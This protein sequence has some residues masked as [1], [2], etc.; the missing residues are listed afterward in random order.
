MNRKPGPPAALTA[1]ELGLLARLEGRPVP[2]AQALAAALGVDASAAGRLI[3]RFRREGVL[4][5]AGVA[6]RPDGACECISYLV[7]DWTKADPE[8]LEARLRCDPAVLTADRILGPADYRLFSRHADFR[9]A[10]AWVRALE[11]EPG[12][13]RVTARFCASVCDRPYY[14]AARL[15][16]DAARRPD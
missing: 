13:S 2:R 16:A 1:R 14:A 7:V 15:A 12:L 5:L 3:R 11:I 10:S 9:A 8:Q 4:T 6:R